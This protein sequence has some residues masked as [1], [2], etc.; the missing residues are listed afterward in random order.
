MTIP[1]TSVL[2]AGIAIRTL[3]KRA[4]IRIDDFAMAAGGSLTPGAATGG[5]DSARRIRSEATAPA[6]RPSR[7]ASSLTAS[8][9][10]A[11]MSS[12]V[13]MR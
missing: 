9:T 8:S 6:D 4:G 1:L 3:R 5:C 7:R 13:R 11:S 10:G 12:V 2:E